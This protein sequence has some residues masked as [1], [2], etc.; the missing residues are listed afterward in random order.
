M[1]TKQVKN[2]VTLYS[3]N[4]LPGRFFRRLPMSLTELK[5]RHASPRGKAYRLND[6]DG[7]FLDVR[8]SGKR[9]WRQRCYLNGLEKILTIGN[10]PSF[11]LVKAREKRDAV[12]EEIAAGQDPCAAVQE[13]K[14]L[15]KYVNAQ[16]FEL[17]ACEWLEAYKARWIEKHY[18]T[19]L[20]RLERHVFPSLGRMPVSKITPPMIYACVRKIEERNSNEL[21][22]R[23]L[24][25]ISQV[26]RY[27]VVTGR[28]QSDQTKDLRGALIPYSKGHFAAISVD[29]L[30]EL[31]QKLR[32][33]E[34]RLLRPTM[35]AMWL[36]LLT[37]VRTSELLQARWEEIDLEK[38]VWRIP[39]ERMKMRKPHIVPLAT[40]AVTLL[41]ELE[42][43]T[44]RPDDW[45]LP[46]YVF[47][48]V[49]RRGK[50]LSSTCLLMALRRMGYY[51]RMTGHGFRALAMSAIKEKLG[52]RHEVVDRQLAHVPKNNVDKAYDRAEFRDERAVMMQD[53]ADYIDSAGKEDGQSG[54]VNP[55]PGRGSYPSR[56]SRAP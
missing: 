23:V 30:P 44:K 33:N 7:L 22:R 51:K 19:M 31:L 45:V 8:P 56:L 6:A 34:A 47:P 49:T 12:R 35:I 48:S 20:S 43:K 26:F 42:T 15:A 10:Y 18:Q 25:I 14:Q 29:E 2:P 21:A 36:M 50:P 41:W 54:T 17:V 38:A 11:S 53:W 28:A 46:N 5:C 37:F 16:T 32:S 27:A 52:Y 39:A 40:Q 9:V 1:P 4:F 55:R 24:N 13:S 3:H